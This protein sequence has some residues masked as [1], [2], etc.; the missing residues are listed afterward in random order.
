MAARLD[1]L[2][3]EWISTSS[4]YTKIPWVSLMTAS[5]SRQKHAGACCSPMATLVH[6]NLPLPGMV[7]AV[8]CLESGCRGTCQYP[9]L[10]SNVEK[11]L[12]PLRPISSMQSLISLMAYFS[13]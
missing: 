2:S 9:L 3:L 1:W 6:S 13:S 10:R 8:Y 5:M 7:N 11:T 4:R 12:D